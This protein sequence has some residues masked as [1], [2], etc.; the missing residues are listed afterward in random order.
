MDTTNQLLQPVA[1]LRTLVPGDTRHNLKVM[2]GVMHD[3]IGAKWTPL[4]NLLTRNG[5]WRCETAI[6]YP[7]N[8]T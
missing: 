8:S 1:T 7:A 3:K 6:S 5:S 4:K 2:M